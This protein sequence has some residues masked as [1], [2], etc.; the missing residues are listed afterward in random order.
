MLHT[1]FLADLHLERMLSL[2]PN[3]SE[4]EGL[5]LQLSA[6][7]KI[8]QYA[9][10]HNIKY[11]IQLG[12]CFHVATPKQSTIIALL[13]LISEFSDIHIFFILGNHD[14]SVIGQHSQ[15]IVAHIG[16]KIKGSNITVFDKPTVI[17][18][19]GIPI[20]FCPWPYNG[21]PTT[22]HLCIGHFDISGLRYANG[23]T[24]VH[25]VERGTLGKDNI[26]IVGHNHTPQFGGNIFNPGT[27]YQIYTNEHYNKK[28][29]EAEV[30]F[31]DNKLTINPIW[32]NFRP[33]Y[34]LQPIE[35]NNENDLTRI[36]DIPNVFWLVTVNP[37]VPPLSSKWLTEH[38]NV[39]SR[40]ARIKQKQIHSI[41]I[42]T[43]QI[44][45][46]FHPAWML[47][48][49]LREHG[50]PLAK[51][52]EAHTIITNILKEIDSKRT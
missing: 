6:I 38:P 36:T 49:F 15:Q 3:L 43:K 11:I 1:L 18:L 14:H 2:L 41:S 51:I 8:F 37:E 34:I 21:A 22:P 26:W 46:G 10:T 33:P 9:R 35:Y 7:R 20:Y 28:V 44:I 24:V 48:S 5:A 45:Q 29:L 32:H 17:K 16:N 42:E 50:L 23:V 40:P 47:D 13:S 19:D 39:M 27:L 25:K 31:E 4:E 12:D 52:S 30:K